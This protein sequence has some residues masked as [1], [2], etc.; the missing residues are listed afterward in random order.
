MRAGALL[1]LCLI[2]AG[3]YVDTP[4][5]NLL[6]TQHDEHFACIYNAC[7]LPMPIL[8]RLAGFHIKSFSKFQGK[9]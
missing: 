1:K 8:M 3:T 2:F 4:I 9:C 6:H 5:I 7:D